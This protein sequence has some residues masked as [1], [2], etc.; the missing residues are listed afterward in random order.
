MKCRHTTRIQVTRTYTNILWK[1][2]QGP[3]WRP[4]VSAEKADTSYKI[5]SVISLSRLPMRTDCSPWVKLLGPNSIYTWIIKP[6]RGTRTMWGLKLWGFGKDYSGMSLHR[7]TTRGPKLKPTPSGP[8]TILFRT[9]PI[10]LEPSLGSLQAIWIT[11]GSAWRW[12][13]VL[14]L[15]IIC[16]RPWQPA[17]SSEKYLGTGSQGER[18]WFWS[19]PSGLY[20]I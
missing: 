19:I 16:C 2:H 8:I 20:K 6:N 4:A 11:N 17:S 13:A 10:I 14:T 18:D 5:G 15:D 1:W 3:R 7:L 9:P 12:V